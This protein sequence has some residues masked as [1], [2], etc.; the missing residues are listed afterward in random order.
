LT[1]K[2]PLDIFSCIIIIQKLKKEESVMAPVEPSDRE[3][4]FFKKLDSGKVS[5]MR[6]ELDK[7]RGEEAKQKRKET[8]WM[9]CPKCGTDLQEVN[10][11]NVM[12]DTCAECQGA[13]LDHGELELLA[14]G[15]AQFS[16][17]FLN[18]IFK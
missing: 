10:Y 11:K 17:G 12:I 9:K 6:G 7:K 1:L 16:K 5:K 3:D 8:H 14:K 2:Y 13:W 4:E 15:E 18:K